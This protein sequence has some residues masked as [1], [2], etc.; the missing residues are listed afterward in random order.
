MAADRLD[1]THTYGWLE[2]QRAQAQFPV[3]FI[4]LH[5]QFKLVDL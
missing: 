5:G 1:M 3:I 4:H 2:T